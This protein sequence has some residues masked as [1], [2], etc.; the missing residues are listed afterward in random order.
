[1]AQQGRIVKVAGPLIVA[2]NMADVRMYDV[3]RVSKNR[4]VGEVIEL[5]GDKASIQVYEET[6]GLGPGEP[7]ESTGAPL[8]VELG[9]GLIESIFDGI[10]RPLTVIAEKYGMHI[11]R[12]VEVPSLNRDKEWGF[13]AL[14]K[15]GDKVTGGT[16]IGQVQESAVVEHR[17][18]VPH[19]IS[20]EIV[21]CESKVARLTDVVAVVRDEKG[22]EHE[23]TMLQKWPVRRGRPYAEKLAPKAP[24]VTGQR[25]ID[26]FFPDCLRRRGGC[27]RPVRFGQNRRAASVGKVG[28]C[29]YHRLRRLRRA[30]QRDDRRSARVPGTA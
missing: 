25:V 12:G 17:I 11:T 16:I 24:M 7:V 3:V 30:R 18:M 2:E 29:G 4:L 9:P 22:V 26:T 19:G 10:Q 6:S 28:G 1:M 23:L 5:R 21:K 15:P 20:G 14:V 13:E 8:S 27:S